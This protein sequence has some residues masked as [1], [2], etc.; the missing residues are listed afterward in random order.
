MLTC[1]SD[2][3][4]G[5]PVF[6][7][8][9]IREKTNLVNQV[10]F[11]DHHQMDVFV[12]DEGGNAVRPWLTAWYDAGSGCLIGWCISTCPN[13]TTT[14]GGIRA[15]GGKENRLAVLRPAGDQL[16]GQR[17]GLSIGTA[18][19]REHRGTRHSARSNA[20]VEGKEILQVIRSAR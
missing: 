7:F 13:S 2:A 4:R 15:S 11:G 3:R 16:R 10:W 19:R 14:R 18:G 20:G 1:A 8:K 12:I 6:A 5:R 9:N 17:Q